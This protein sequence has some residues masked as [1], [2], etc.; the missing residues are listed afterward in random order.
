MYIDHFRYQK[1]K[2]KSQY[3]EVIINAPEGQ[4]G[5]GMLELC[6]LTL[7][8]IETHALNLF[9]CSR[10]SC[11]TARLCCLHVDNRRYLV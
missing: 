8:T 1:V 3:I 5:T 4:I 2:Y 7:T 6:T 11:V 9:K 10:E